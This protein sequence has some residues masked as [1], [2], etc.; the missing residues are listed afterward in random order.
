MDGTRRF[1]LGILAVVLCKYSQAE[2]NTTNTPAN[3][4]VSCDLHD[5]CTGSDDDHTWSGHFSKCP[6]E[7][8]HYCVHGVCR[9]VKAQ[10]TP[11]CRCETG[12]IGSRCEY[13]DLDLRVEERMK[14]VIACV[15]AGLV[16]LILLFVFICV[17]THK[18]YKPCRKKKRKKETSDEDEKL[19]SLNIHEALTAP[20]NTSDTNDV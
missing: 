16:F 7:Y 18:R 1:I 11:S 6:K 14:I 4:T 5:N 9:F 19:S 17:C 2:W 15:V 3:R 20:V 10:N 12:Y 8:K 13:R